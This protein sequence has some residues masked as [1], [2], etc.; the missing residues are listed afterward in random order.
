M[1]SHLDVRNVLAEIAREVERPEIAGR[2]MDQALEAVRE[3]QADR[4]AVAAREVR[5]DGGGFAARQAQLNEMLLA[6]I[7]EIATTAEAAS[8]DA[9]HTDRFVRSAIAAAAH[10][11][12]D[13]SAD[14]CE[15]TADDDGASAPRTRRA[16][17]TKEASEVA[18]DGPSGVRRT[19]NLEEIAGGEPS[20][21]IR[22][23]VT[24]RRLR[25]PIVGWLLGRV[26]ARIHLLS[27]SYAQ[28][29]AVS[30]ESINRTLAERVLD[31]VAR[32]D[33]QEEEI[34]ALTLQLAVARRRIEALEV[35]AA[36]ASNA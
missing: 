20:D 33:E 36:S 6:L 35:N 5:G 11:L 26:Q 22:P 14:P 17:R 21:F 18:A 8:S 3:F 7:G 34:E 9:R 27:L 13:A 28:Q 1:V 2:R 32:A 16:R 25:I 31:L 10:D 19:P 30:Q 24:A 4:L 23:Q 15:A 29:V 12:G